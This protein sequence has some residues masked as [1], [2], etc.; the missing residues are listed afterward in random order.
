MS[1]GRRI[2][3]PFVATRVEAVT[4]DGLILMTDSLH[5][6]RQRRVL[7]TGY[8]AGM[9]TF[10][11]VLMRFVVHDTKSE[12]GFV[13]VSTCLSVLVLAV[14]VWAVIDVWRHWIET[15]WER[16]TMQGAFRRREMRWDSV[17]AAVWQVGAV[18]LC[19]PTQ[20]MRIRLG[21]YEAENALLLVEAIRRALPAAVHRDERKYYPVGQDP[22]IDYEL[23][24]ADTV[25]PKPELPAPIVFG[26]EDLVPRVERRQ[27]VRSTIVAGLVV[28]AAVTFWLLP[29]FWFGHVVVLFFMFGFG[30]LSVACGL[31]S[32]AGKTG[33]LEIRS[34]R[35]THHQ[36]RSNTDLPWQDV[37]KLLWST[38]RPAAIELL[39]DVQRLR[40]GLSDFPLEQRLALIRRF[41]DGFPRSLQANWPRFCHSVALPLREAPPPD[42]I[43]TSRVPGPDEYVRTRW[44]V[45]RVVIA[46][47]VCALGIVGAS[48]YFLQA[49]TTFPGQSLALVWVCL[50]PLA[51]IWAFLRF[52]IPAGGQ[53]AKVRRWSR[54]DSVFAL[55]LFAIFA[56][57][58]LVELGKR[59]GFPVVIAG[60]LLFLS[61]FFLLRRGRAKRRLSEKL[62]REGLDRAAQDSARKWEE[63][64]AEESRDALGR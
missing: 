36:G 54:E 61:P 47:L 56:G 30:A 62:E 5:I 31:A 37:R 35:I 10:L 9:S 50:W 46:F 55:G 34:D 45:D 28:V 11:V 19:S 1:S 52:S 21:K 18:K 15:D 6:R 44:H 20:K 26:A 48:Q 14:S 39:G 42:S 24:S 41:R 4:V 59:I 13:E 8:F 2:D 58:F 51:A 57:Y 3:A 38:A 32:G 49:F 16:I 22:N 53:I 63:L 43:P 12:P 17:E 7:T 29:L 25:G 33:P 64:D 40:I 23:P 27:V 60:V